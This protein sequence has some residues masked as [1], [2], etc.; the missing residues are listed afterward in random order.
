MVVPSEKYPI[1]GADMYQ[2]IIIMIIVRDCG[3][4]DKRWIKTN[5]WE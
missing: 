5:T 4:V 3:G 2:V 1:V